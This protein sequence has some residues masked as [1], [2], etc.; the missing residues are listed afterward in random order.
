[1]LVN[2]NKN[3]HA[4][5]KLNFN[6]RKN[7]FYI[8]FLLSRNVG[9]LINVNFLRGGEEKNIFIQI[10]TRSSPMFFTYILDGGN[11]FSFDR[12]LDVIAPLYRNKF[13][14]YNNKSKSISSLGSSSSLCRSLVSVRS[15]C[16]CS[17]RGG[18]VSILLIVSTRY[19]SAREMKKRKIYIY[20]RNYASVLNIIIFSCIFNIY[21]VDV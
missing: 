18:R 11:C 13:P 8:I 6:R 5:S 15:C 10:E 7:L 12:Q 1:M 2:F 4:F 21:Y 19:S 14:S 20:I 9:I 3:Y 16:K 17:C